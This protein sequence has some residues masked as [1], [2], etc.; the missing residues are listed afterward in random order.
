MNVMPKTVTRGP[1]NRKQI[2]LHLQRNWSEGTQ[3]DVVIIENPPN[4][5]ATDGRNRSTRIWRLSSRRQTLVI[6]D[7][8]LPKRRHRTTDGDGGFQRDA[9]EPTFASRLRT[10][11]E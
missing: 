6:F 7:L 4:V 11:D 5:G 1:R 9:V 8:S 2:E 10:A 3:S